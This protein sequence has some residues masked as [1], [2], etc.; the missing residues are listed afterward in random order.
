M[1]P[2]PGVHQ[3][4]SRGPLATGEVVVAAASCHV[5]VNVSSCVRLCYVSCFVTLYIVMLPAWHGLDP[6]RWPAEG[7]G[8]AAGVQASGGRVEGEGGAL[9]M[10][11]HVTSCHVT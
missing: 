8:W 11:R 5:N 3:A 6:G 1:L 9:S 10:S 4:T 2:A 7:V